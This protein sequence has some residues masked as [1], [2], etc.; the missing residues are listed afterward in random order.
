M[1]AVSVI[2][3]SGISIDRQGP[4]SLA[5]HLVSAAEA[6]GL[7]S[8]QVGLPLQGGAGTCR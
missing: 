6:R 4:P 8:A 5:G 3:L 2:E 7:L 1:L